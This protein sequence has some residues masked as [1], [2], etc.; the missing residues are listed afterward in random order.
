MF[1]DPPPPGLHHP[2]GEQRGVIH[3]ASPAFLL[4]SGIISLFVALLI[5]VILE[6]W[7][8]AVLANTFVIFSAFSFFCWK[9]FTGMQNLKRRL[10]EM[11]AE[12]HQLRLQLK[13]E[14]K[15]KD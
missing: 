4:L 2:R 1:F 9:P 14:E 5:P 8:L 6:T 15:G 11:E 3:I 10:K 12:I 13:E 7:Y